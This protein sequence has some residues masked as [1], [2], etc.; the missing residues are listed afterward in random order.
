[1]PDSTWQNPLAQPAVWNL[2]AEAYVAE[3]VAHFERYAEDAWRLAAP[4]PQ[5][6]VVDVATGPGT[7]ALL[8][9]RR[10]AHVAAIDFAADMIAELKRRLGGITSIEARVG[11]GQ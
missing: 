10:G 2:V 3:N 8:A 5:A 11:D 7:L 1:M 4:P 9:A 6:R